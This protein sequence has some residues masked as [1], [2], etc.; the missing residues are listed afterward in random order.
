MSLRRGLCWLFKGTT[1]RGTQTARCLALLALPAGLSAVYVGDHGDAS[2]DG[3]FEERDGVLVELLRERAPVFARVGSLARSLFWTQ[4]VAYLI[5]EIHADELERARSTGL[6]TE[7]A[8]LRG[9]RD[10]GRAAARR[11]APWPSGTRSG[12]P[13]RSS[14]R[15]SARPDVV[16]VEEMR[17]TSRIARFSSMRRLNGARPA[18]RQQWCIRCG[19]P[20]LVTGRA[21]SCPHPTT[22]TQDC[23]AKMHH[24]ALSQFVSENSNQSAVSACSWVNA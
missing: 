2:T 1:A 16:L 14:S 21:S 19:L 15:A 7:S 10:V 18:K 8:S 9:R 6:D 23:D 4:D 3:G 13:S 22:H 20:A 12:G 24:G 17:S 11:V 5:V